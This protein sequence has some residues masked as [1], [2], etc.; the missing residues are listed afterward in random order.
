MKVLKAKDYLV[1][2]WKNGLGTTS[3]IKIFPQTASLAELN[4]NWRLS[5]ASITAENDF[6]LFPE[7]KRI[8]TVWDGKGIRLNQLLLKPFEI[9]CFEGYEKINCELIDGKVEDLGLIYDPNEVKAEMKIISKGKYNL[10]FD[11][12]FLF[13][14]QN[15]FSVGEFKINCGE[16]LEVTHPQEIEILE[17]TKIIL[18]SLSQKIQH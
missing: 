16:C 12:H 17:N 3:Q 15:N 1:S 18:I 10:S 7:Y 5:Q 11:Q 8:L 13:C 9:F 2:P 4:F 6:S 14:A